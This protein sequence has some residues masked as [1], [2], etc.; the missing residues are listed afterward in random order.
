MDTKNSKLSEKL[1]SL[2]PNI[3]NINQ[4]KIAEYYEAINDAVERGVSYKAIRE[5][6][7]EEGFKMSPATFKRLFDAECELRAKSDVVQRRGA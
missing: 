7:A 4:A 2:Q 1:K 5:A 6:L 3:R